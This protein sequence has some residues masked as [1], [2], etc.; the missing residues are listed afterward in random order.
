MHETHTRVHVWLPLFSIQ[1]GDST[2]VTSAEIAINNGELLLQAAISVAP[3][4]YSIFL[5]V[6]PF[7]LHAL[8]NRD[9]LSV[10]LRC[11]LRMLS[12]HRLYK[13]RGMRL[14]LRRKSL[15]TAN[16]AVQFSATVGRLVTHRRGRLFFCT[17][18]LRNFVSR[19]RLVASHG[20]RLPTDADEKSPLLP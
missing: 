16:I 19:K 7:V 4:A 13:A 9:V 3:Q 6:S 12:Y 20:S 5:F 15:S 14:T 8:P 2:I 17:V 18:I 1:H 11:L 10:F